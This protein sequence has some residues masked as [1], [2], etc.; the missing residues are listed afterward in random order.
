MPEK[1]IKVKKILTSVKSLIKDFLGEATA[2]QVGGTPK[3][4]S[5]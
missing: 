3:L 2:E 1:F 4:N 5:E